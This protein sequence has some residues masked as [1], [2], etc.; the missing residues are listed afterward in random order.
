M[1]T[2]LPSHRHRGGLLPTPDEPSAPR[3]TLV[4]LVSL[5]A[6]S[7]LGSTAS[8]QDDPTAPTESPRVTGSI[9]FK[10]AP[11]LLDPSGSSVNWRVPAPGLARE[12]QL[13]LEQM[14]VV[15]SRSDAE[16]SDEAERVE[17]TVGGYAVSPLTLAARPGV[18]LTFTNA[19][20]TGYTLKSVGRAAIKDIELTEPGK[21]AEMTL[22]KPG[23]YVFQDLQ[24]PSVLVYI[25]VMDKVATSSLTQTS[26]T[27][28]TFDLGSVAPG[29]YQLTPSLRGKPIDEREIKVSSTGAAPIEFLLTGEDL[30]E[31]LD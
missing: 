20:P 24:H 25:V 23:R 5:F 15:L 16:A 12:P 6:A 4:L 8:A 19:G 2:G 14:F 13:P 10:D 21:A 9:L 22:E 11:A 3:W 29:S 28:A 30:L 7:L 1:E 26:P 18:A 27:K 17:L 31:A